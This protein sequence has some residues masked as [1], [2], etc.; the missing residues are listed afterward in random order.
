MIVKGKDK[1]RMHRH[2][3]VAD[4][5]SL[6]QNNGQHITPLS[7]CP[8]NTLCI[9]VCNPIKKTKEIGINPGKE[10]FVFKNEPSDTNMIISLETTRYIIAK[11]IADKILVRNK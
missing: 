6:N 1:K 9:V 4:K 3:S 11:T 2:G 5:K 7:N 10:V 8:P